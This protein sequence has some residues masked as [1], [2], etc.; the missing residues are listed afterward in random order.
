MNF[1]KDVYKRQDVVK[2]NENSEEEKTEE[3]N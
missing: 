1:I 2:P 3:N